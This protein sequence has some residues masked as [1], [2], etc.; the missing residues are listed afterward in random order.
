M[1][2]ALKENQDLLWGFDYSPDSIEKL[3]RDCVE[4]EFEIRENGKFA[5]L[6]DVNRFL[7]L[8]R[9]CTAI[10]LESVR[11]AFHSVYKY[12]FIKDHFPDEKPVIEDILTGAEKI[13]AEKNNLD[14]IQKL[15][16]KWLCENLKDILLRLS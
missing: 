11:E 15:Q 2:H 1:T 8:L 5:S 4:H 14:R 16:L 6:L 12:A 3:Y 10:Q 13:L 7:T 9:N